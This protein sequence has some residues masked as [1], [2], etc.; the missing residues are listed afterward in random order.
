M[1]EMDE[2][3]CEVCEEELEEGAG[4]EGCAHC[5]RMFGPCCNSLVDGYCNECD[6]YAEEGCDEEGE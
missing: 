3:I 1:G 4:R 5:G 2:K 6:I